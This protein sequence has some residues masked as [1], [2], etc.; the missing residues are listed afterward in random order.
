MAYPT[1]FRYTKDHEW[2]ALEASRAKIG[3]TEYAQGELGDIVFVELPA[4]GTKVNQGKNLATVESVKAVSDV[5]APISGKVLEVNEKLE[6]S[7][8]LINQDPHG[9]GWLVLLEVSDSSESVGLLDAA[10]YERYLSE[11]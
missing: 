4:P 10:G 7:P 6:S 3:I 11:K 8:E 1:Q 9:A 5:Y 2:V